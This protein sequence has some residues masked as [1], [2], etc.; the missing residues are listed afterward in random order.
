MGGRAREK[1]DWSVSVVVLEYDEK[2]NEV[3][4]WV[5]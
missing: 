4:L 5:F 1:L 3:F 2:M